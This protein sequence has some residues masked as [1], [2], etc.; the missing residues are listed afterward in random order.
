MSKLGPFEWGTMKR[1]IRRAIDTLNMLGWETASH[2]YRGTGQV[3]IVSQIGAFDKEAVDKAAMVAE[4][5]GRGW[6]AEFGVIGGI[7]KKDRKGVSLR[8]L[9]LGEETDFDEGPGLFRRYTNPVP[10]KHA[11]LGAVR[12]YGKGGLFERVYG[13]RMSVFFVVVRLVGPP[14]A[15]KA[16]KAPMG[17]KPVKAK[18]APTRAPEPQETPKPQRRDAKGRFVKP[19]PVKLPKRDKQGRFMARKAKSAK[20]A[21]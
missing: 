5:L 2:V 14:E 15:P 7:S 11:I 18:R 6:S 16:T 21:R 10:S 1:N 9:V 17:P 4:S 3:E 12:L 8:D 19:K 20:G 13:S